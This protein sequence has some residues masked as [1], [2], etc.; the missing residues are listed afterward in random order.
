MTFATLSL[1]AIII[2]LLSFFAVY[3]LVT[4]QWLLALVAV[5]LGSGGLAAI[6]VAWL[7]GAPR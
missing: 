3:P 4:S 1:L 6:Y 7:R 5:P 2:G